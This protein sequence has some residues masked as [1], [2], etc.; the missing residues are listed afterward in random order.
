MMQA[1]TLTTCEL[2]K[3]LGT[4]YCAHVSTQQQ[5]GLIYFPFFNAD[6]LYGGSS[7]TPS[8]RFK[9]S[10][11]NFYSD[12]LECPVDLTFNWLLSFS[13]VCTLVFLV[14]LEA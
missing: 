8:F 14:F 13:C 6:W 2:L 7:T 11:T 4:T 9:H 5:D 3:Q 10:H 1:R 12:F